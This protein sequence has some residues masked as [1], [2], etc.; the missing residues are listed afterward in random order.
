MDYFTAFEISKSGLLAEKLRMDIVALNISNA[1]SI[2]G[3]RESVYK[4]MTVYT[5]PKTDTSLLN[6]FDSYL[7][8]Q[9]M[10]G[11]DIVSVESMET[12]VQQ[13]FDPD[14]PYADANGYT[15]R[16]DINPA[17]EMIGM[18]NSLRAYQA[19]V[20]AISAAKSMA[21]EALRIGTR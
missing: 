14:N 8:N 20:K 3:S 19:N 1:N 15:F 10:L 18:I 2:M 21:E 12:R 5:A 13:V 11:V 16:P 7:K 17:S 4:P 6:N 9:Q